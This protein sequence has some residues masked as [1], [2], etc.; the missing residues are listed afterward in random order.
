MIER[1]VT[2]RR[3]RGP[4]A[5][6]ALVALGMGATATTSGAVVAGRLVT[7]VTPA[8]L[9]WFA[10]CVVGG[11]VI[12]TAGRF[13]WA[14][15]ADRAEG[16]L[17]DDLLR[18]ALTQPLAQLTEQ[19]VGE[20]LDRIDDDTREIGSLVRMPIWMVLRAVV[21]M[22]PMLVVAAFTWWPAVLLFPLF[23]AGALGAIRPLLGPIATRKVAEEEAW[24]D[25]AAALEEGIAGRDDLRTSLGQPFA[26]RRVAA[27]SARVH[28]LFHA[29]LRLEAQVTLRSGLVLNALL[30]VVVVVGVFAVHAGWW[31]VSRLVTLFVL[32]STFVG[33]ISRV[34]DQLPD[35]QAGMGAVI[36][37]RQM[38]AVDP[39]PSGGASLTDGTLDLEFRH[40]T[41]AYAE[42]T[43]ALQDIDLT[44]PGGR[45]LALVGRTGSGKSTL[46]SLISRAVEPSPGQIFLGGTDITELDLEALRHA[47]GVVTQRTEIL[48]GT[49]E[50][51]IA[52]FAEVPRERTQAVVDELGLTDWVA[53]LP[54]GLDTPIGPGG[55][56]LSAGEEQLLA[57]ARLLMRD[58]QVVVLDEATA[59]MDPL[60]EARVVEAS[61]RLLRGRT[62]IL[63]AHRM[64][65]IRRA[66]LVAVLERGRVAQFGPQTELAAE[67]GHFRELLLASGARRES[68][69][70]SPA[71]PGPHGGDQAPAT[72]CVRAEV[73]SSTEA[74]GAIGTPAADAAPGAHAD[75]PGPLSSGAPGASTT[76]AAL[77]S[78]GSARRRGEPPAQRDP[79]DG[80]SLAR[81]VWSMLRVRPRWGLTAVVLFLLFALGGAGGA[82][83]GWAWGHVVVGLERGEVPWIPMVGVVLFAVTAPVLLAQAVMR[84]PRWW[85]EVLLRVRMSV[86]LGQTAQRRLDKVPPGEVVARAMDS[87][88][89]ARYADRWVDFTNGLL[90][91]VVTAV[92][93][94]TPLAGLVLLVVMIVSA[95]ASAAGRPLAGRS[96]ATASTARATFGRM[97]VSV[98]ESAR[99]VKLAGRTG[100]VHRHLSGVDHIRVE[101]AVREHRVQAVLDGVPT[102]LVQAGVV[103]AWAAV[104]GGQWGLA[105]ALLVAN[106]VGG[107]DWFG[108]VAGAVVTEAPGTR[109]W[110]VATSRL[111]GGVDL[112]EVPA[113]IDLVTGRAP[114][115]PRIE[116][117]PLDTLTLRDFEAV[118]EDGTIGVEH[119][120]LQVRRGQ[121][122]LLTGQVGAGKS[123][124]LK[125]LAGLTDHRG[126]M[127]WNGDEVEDPEVFC[128][129]GQVAYVAQ[130]PRVMSGTFADNIR[131]G[132]DRP[133][134]RPVREAR[135]E[136]DVDDA[137]GPH[138]VI[139]HRGVRLSGG[140]VQRLAFA[141]ALAADAELLLADDVSSALDARTEIDLWKGL[142]AR[143]STVIGSSSKRA[144]LA[145]ADLV[146]VLVDGRIAAQGPWSQLSESWGHLAG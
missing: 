6:A 75:V 29:V 129:P 67:D 105:T 94:G 136:S 59:R 128:R 33:Y 42:G 146:V 18:A 101:A 7:G 55:T 34:A 100:E 115:P 126:A 85:V 46:A 60:T 23:A 19:A 12:D 36:R 104:L 81:G 89:Y 65:T 121:L 14:G 123:S 79:G 41:F 72:A 39:E 88:R 68:E 5:A 62:G 3:L 47:V 102:I 70:G 80:P 134:D 97:L 145:Q 37:L 119:V 132:F 142:R 13:L 22:V 131:L 45:T 143:S 103:V 52:L 130:V 49:L 56:T 21:T 32:T 82:L 48:A 24:T 116:R 71:G 117:V 140:Q 137:G 141:R 11:A 63:I 8:L 73:G 111:A 122:V 20:V 61:D 138:S 57:F 114:E 108:R 9:G 86:L 25:H 135:L 66:D 50:E 93:A 30:G 139:G 69:P 43:F 76:P 77:P 53:G 16:R 112:M 109:A 26:V 38:L 40:V 83:T 64:S 78:L 51:N 10:L 125:A 113:G 58:V 99:T 17:R 15:V 144:A 92:A 35:I 84:Y 110:Q 91:A 28:E 74:N 107:F 2:W 120:D 90:I 4:V 95:L 31:D 98:L 124:L 54:E 96:A 133:L 27:L 118:H 1:T 127:L 44:V 87:D 106:A